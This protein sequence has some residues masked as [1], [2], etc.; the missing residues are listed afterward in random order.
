MAVC[1]A[2]GLNIGRSLHL[3]PYF[4][5]AGSEG[6]GESVLMSETSLSVNAILPKSLVIGCNREDSN[7]LQGCKD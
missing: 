4:L 1:G 6:S 7:R 5:Y 3:H 2:M